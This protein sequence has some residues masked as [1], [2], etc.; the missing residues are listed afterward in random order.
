M[1]TMTWSF[2]LR[3]AKELVV[4]EVNTFALLQV[5]TFPLYSRAKDRSMGAW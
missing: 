5:G 4:L 3:N 2:S 1:A